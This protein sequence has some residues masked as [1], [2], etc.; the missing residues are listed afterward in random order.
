MAGKLTLPLGLGGAGKSQ[1]SAVMPVLCAVQGDPDGLVVDLARRVAWGSYGEWV[2][3][4][5]AAPT[6]ALRPV[7]VGAGPVVISLD[8][9][10]TASGATEM[11]P[12]R[13]SGAFRVV[14]GSLAQP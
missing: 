5:P 12:G 3:P 7:E 1:R 9:K 11:R 6:G 13:L 4:D 2:V 10:E 8:P 14:A